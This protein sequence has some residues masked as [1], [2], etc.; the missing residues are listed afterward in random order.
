MLTTITII[1][2]AVT[3]IDTT[4]VAHTLTGLDT[5]TTASTLQYLVFFKGDRLASQPHFIIPH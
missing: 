2:V 4:F 5:L 3:T 1:L